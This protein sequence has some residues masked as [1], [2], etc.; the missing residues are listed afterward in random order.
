MSHDILELEG[1]R[2]AEVK[3][4]EEDVDCVDTRVWLWDGDEYEE[5][6][7]DYL[8][9][10]FPYKINKKTVTKGAQFV[11]HFLSSSLHYWVELQQE[12]ETEPDKLGSKD[13]KVI[14]E[15]LKT[16][17]TDNWIAF[18]RWGEN[19]NKR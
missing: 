19:F 8:N 13:I 4:E 16:D 3:P 9:Q 14:E 12:G 10:I 6:E 2:E 5:F 7:S 17:E 15:I 1:R 11:F 18:R